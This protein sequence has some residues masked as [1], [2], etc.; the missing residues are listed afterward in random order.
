MRCAA[1]SPGLA[2]M[3]LASGFSQEPPNTNYDEAEVPQND[4]PDPLVCFD[5]RPVTDSRTWREVRRP[6]ILEAFAGHAYGRIPPLAAHLRFEV[7]AVEPR[8]LEGRATRREVRV[9]L[10]EPVNAHGLIACIAPR[11]VYV[12]SAEQDRQQAK[13]EAKRKDDSH[14]L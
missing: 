6:E 11:P 2:L 9:R 13:P 14:Q 10:F 4:L 3:I 12:A 8:A 7:T 1:F 5:A